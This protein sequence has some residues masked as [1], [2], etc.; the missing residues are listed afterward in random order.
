[1]VAVGAIIE[2]AK[3]GKILLLKRNSKADFSPGIWEEITG[4]MKQFEEL[5]EALKGEIKEESRIEEIKIVKPLTINHFFRGE[6]AADKEIILII[7]WCI[8]EQEKVVISGEH[9]DFAWLP[10]KEALSLVEHPGV[11]NDIETFIK[12]KYGR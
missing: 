4:R 2:N 7:Y 6:R 1:M 9:E 11:K 3:T 10:P 12:E 8:T 5:E